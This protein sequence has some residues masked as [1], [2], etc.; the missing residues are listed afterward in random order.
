MGPCAKIYSPGMGGKYLSGCPQNACHLSMGAI[1]GASAAS[2]LKT[3]ICGLFP[4]GMPS[5]CPSRMPSDCHLTAIPD[6]SAMEKSGGK[7]WPLFFCIPSP[8]GE[9][10]GGGGRAR[11]PGPGE[12]R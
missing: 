5:D 12:A 9:S 3:F 11:G 1:P 8:R 6:S 10:K 2:P 4:L 7:F